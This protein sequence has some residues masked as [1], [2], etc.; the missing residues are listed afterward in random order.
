MQVKD[1]TVEQLQTLIRNTVDERLNEYLADPDQ[2]KEIKELFMQSLLNVRKKRMEGR[3]TIPAS[4]VYKKYGI[5][6]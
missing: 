3:S 4:E 6:Q 1:L 5:R 2:E